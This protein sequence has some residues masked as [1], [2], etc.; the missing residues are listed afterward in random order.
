M[1]RTAAILQRNTYWLFCLHIHNSHNQIDHKPPISVRMDSVVAV[2]VARKSVRIVG[3][4]CAV[5]NLT[6]T[7][8][9]TTVTAPD[10]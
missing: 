8:A 1:R 3:Y 9:K 5:N 4:V 7:T 10:L 2:S 6:L